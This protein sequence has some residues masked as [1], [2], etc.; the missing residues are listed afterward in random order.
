M[1][2]LYQFPLCPFSRKVRLLLGEKGVGYEPVRESPWLRRDEFLDLNPTGQVPVM[3]DDE[4]GVTLIDSQVICE[5]F[6]ETV[7]KA[8]MLNGTATDR[9]EIRRLAI[10][11][12]TNFYAEI[13]APLLHERMLKRIV[14]KQSP[15]GQ[16]L[17]NAMKAAVNHLDYIDY[18][19]DHRTWLAGPTMSLADL[20]AAAQISIA[21]YLGGIDWKSHEQAK[22]W[23]IRMKSR[24]SFRPLLSERM[25]GI[26]PPADYEKLDL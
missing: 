4:R 10:W 15:D 24:P 6:E 7:N 14:Y 5:F 23:Y 12:D 19:L 9:A 8:P 1:W 16:A 18:L 2:Q 17:R 3:V 22:G 26:P 25:E 20:A 13:T 11:F 21:D